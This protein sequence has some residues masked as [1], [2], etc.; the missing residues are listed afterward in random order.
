MPIRSKYKPDNKPIPK[1][2]MR[3]VIDAWYFGFVKGQYKMSDSHKLPLS[4]TAITANF[5]DVFGLEYDQYTDDRAR[6]VWYKMQA[7]EKSLKRLQHELQQG[8]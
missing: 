4:L 7:E 6:E 1:L 8:K 2:L 3:S 5:R